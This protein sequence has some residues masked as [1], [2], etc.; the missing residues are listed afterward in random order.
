MGKIFNMLMSEN[1]FIVSS[2]L[3]GVG[4]IINK[5]V[6]LYLMLLLLLFRS[7]FEIETCDDVGAGHKNWNNIL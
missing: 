2:S 5:S 4:K 3:E 6:A 1:G 7:C